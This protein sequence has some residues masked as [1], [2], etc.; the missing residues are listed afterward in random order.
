MADVILTDE[1]IEWFE[2]LA[3][4]HSRAVANKIDLLGHY[5]VKLGFPDSSAIAGT[6][7]PIR[8]LRV[9]SH[10]EAV[11]VFYAFDPRRDAVLILGGIKTSKRFYKD[12]IPKVGKIWE[13]YMRD[14]KAGRYG[15]E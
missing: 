10:G 3:E 1:F 5:G 15:S 4:K 9:Q 7:H 14:L 12:L 11:R 6:K 2:A 13:Q 8:E